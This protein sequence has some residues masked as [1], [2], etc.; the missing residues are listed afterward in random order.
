MTEPIRWGWLNW[1]TSEAIWSTLIAAQVALLIIGVTYEYLGL[2]RWQFPWNP[3]ETAIPLTLPVEFN[4]ENK[5]WV[6]ILVRSIFATVVAFFVWLDGHWFD[7]WPWESVLPTR[8][9]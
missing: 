3:N 4:I 2:I 5:L 9:W 6:R 7:W 1:T 8:P